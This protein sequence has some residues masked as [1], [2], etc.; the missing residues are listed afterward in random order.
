M[1]K[2]RE[3]KMSLIGEILKL[4]FGAFFGAW[5]AF[6]FERWTRRKDEKARHLNACRAAQFAFSCQSNLL[7][8]V[9]EQYLDT[10]R[11]DENRWIELHPFLVE[12]NAPRI[13]WGELSFILEGSKANI[14]KKMTI[15]QANYITCLRIIETRNKAHVAFQK[16][17]ASRKF[18]DS[19]LQKVL[20]DLTD[21]L[22]VLIDDTINSLI[23]Q[24]VIL[25]EFITEYFPGKSTYLENLNE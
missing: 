5:C 12:D 7:R 20:T 19:H 21:K 4:G 6:R 17:Y 22:Y 9:Q 3:E 13:D 25:D 15:A 2:D 16:D 8:N 10:N 18:Y 1:P 14:L 23:E 24:I 11:T